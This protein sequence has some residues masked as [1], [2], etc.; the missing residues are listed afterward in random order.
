MES[1]S[2]T[3]ILQSWQAYFPRLTINDPRVGQRQL[4]EIAAQEDVA[5]RLVVLPTGY[6]KTMSGLGYYVVRRGR[7]LVNRC[8][9]IVSSDEQRK[10]LSPVPTKDGRRDTTASDRVQTWFGVPCLETVRADG[11]HSTLRMHFEGH[12]EIFATTYQTLIHNVAYF[13]ELM[14]GAGGRWQWLVIADEAHHLSDDGAWAAKLEELS[15]VESL[16][17]SATPVRTDRR[18]LR[19][20]PSTTEQYD[21]CVEVSWR[22]AIE[23]GAIRQPTAHAEEWSLQFEDRRGELVTIT[24]DELRDAGVTTE[25]DF[26]EYQVKHDLRYTFGFLD[27]I[28]MHALNRLNEKR[29]QWPGRHQM[30]VFAMS[31]SHAKFLANEVFGRLTDADWIGVTRGD[32]ENE[33][34]LARFK[35]GDLT[36][37]VQVDKAGEGFDHPPASVALFLNMVQSQTK[38]LQQLGRVL[39]RDVQ[40]PQRQDIADVFADTAHPVVEVV[41]ELEPDDK[42]YRTPVER[43]PSGGGVDDWQPVPDML[44]IEAQWRQTQLV[45]PLGMVP[46][47]EPGVL[48]AAEQFDLPPDKVQAILRVAQ[49]AADVDEASVPAVSGETQR[50]ALFR[51]RVDRLLSTVTGHA[52]TLLLRDSPPSVGN[53]KQLAGQLKK[54]LNGRWVKSRRRGHDDMLSED[55]VQKYDWLRQVDEDMRLTKKVPSWLRHGW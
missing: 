24:T 37:L 4:W 15:R 35:R 18:P 13:R 10:Q 8:L 43:D 29:V 32:K 42:G 26:D 34:A 39:R 27:K 25:A 49:G 5:D 45:L 50:Q 36:V 16:Y 55:F 46:H 12:A 7:G 54:R 44:E 48:Q 9:W 40:I 53:P 19:N 31:C 28:F 22:D 23:E 38:L 30:L 3:P 14:D 51:D 21:A 52:I 1:S 33:Q 11:M 6:G 17:L 2:D 20:V 47:Y 41:R